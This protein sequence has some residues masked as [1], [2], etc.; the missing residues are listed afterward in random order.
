MSQDSKALIA[1]NLRL[2]RLE[3]GFK[4]EELSLIVGRDNSYISKLENARMNATINKL[5]CIATALN[6]KT[7]DLFEDI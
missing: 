2:K 4:Q 1:K 7:K 5:D 6:I 3:C